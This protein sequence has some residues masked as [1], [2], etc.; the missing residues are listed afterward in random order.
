MDTLHTSVSFPRTYVSMVTTIT[1]SMA[2]LGPEQ[3]K[4]FQDNKPLVPTNWYAN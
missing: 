3:F 2:I 1:Y 4:L